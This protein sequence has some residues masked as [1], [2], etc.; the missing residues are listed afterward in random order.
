V[1]AGSASGLDWRDS[2]AYAPLLQADRSLFAWE[3][4]RRDP[5]YRAAAGAAMARGGATSGM[6][7]QFGLVAFEDPNLP[8]PGARPLWAS[9]VHP[10][11]LLVT[12]GRDAAADA[13][14]LDRFAALA[15]MVEDEGGEHL[16][17]SDGLRTVRL[18]GPAD[19]FRGGPVSLR[20]HLKG[21]AAA[22]RPLLSLRRFLALCRKGSFS[23]TLHQP[24]H[25]ARRWIRMLR[26]Y[27]A[28]STGADQREIARE[29]LSRSVGDPRWR[30]REPS[31]R[32]Q[33][34]RLVRSARHLAAGGYRALLG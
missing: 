8:V 11:V 25:S 24:E 1:Q 19:T 4:L 20:Y 5:I 27:D 32:S 10:Y 15:K 26:A 23:R 16:L 17:L 3:W 6:P 30:S 29:L 12:R 18:D 9:G 2:A 28:L 31:V 21:V 14:D 33:V 22:E 13:F 7:G 34:Q